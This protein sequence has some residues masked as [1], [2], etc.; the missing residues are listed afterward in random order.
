MGRLNPFEIKRNLAVDR[1]PFL[2]S[3]R[4]MA[5]RKGFEPSMGD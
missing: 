1:V 2:V 5:E 4:E 3:D